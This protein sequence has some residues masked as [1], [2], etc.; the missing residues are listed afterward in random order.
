[1]MIRNRDWIDAFV[2]A[3][4]VVCSACTRGEDP[5]VAAAQKAARAAENENAAKP[6]EAAFQKAVSE[7]NWSLAKAHADVLMA[8]YPHTEAAARVRANYDEI[9][10][11]ADAAKD[12]QRLQGLWTYNAEKVQGGRQLSASI[13]ARDEIDVGGGKKSQVRLIFRD[14]PSWGRSSYLVLQSGDF[15]CYRGCKVQVTIN[16]EKPVSIS[17]SRP[18]TDEAIAMFI[19]NEKAL[20]RIVKSAKTVSVQF[21]VKNAGKQTAVFETGGLSAEKLPGW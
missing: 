7:E 5:Q 4:C 3:L 21:P 6:G 16:D 10:R 8:S 17:A 20:W 13:F 14:H 11:N 15:D 19:E 9:K 18:K 12:L 2:L 1:M